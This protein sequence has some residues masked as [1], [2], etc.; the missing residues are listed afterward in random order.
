MMRAAQTLRT[1]DRVAR[2]AIARSGDQ[3]ENR[4]A[5]AQFVRRRT[6]SRIFA[7]ASLRSPALVRDTRR[8]RRNVIYVIYGKPPSSMPNRVIYARGRH[9]C[10]GTAGL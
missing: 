2:S 9:L 10:A 3:R 7:P 6:G 1:P 8:A 5:A 4:R